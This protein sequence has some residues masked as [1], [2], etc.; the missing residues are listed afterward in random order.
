MGAE[1]T[2]KEGQLYSLHAE[3]C[4]SCSI[5]GDGTGQPCKR[6][7]VE[8]AGVLPC[9]LFCLSPKHGYSYGIMF[10]PK[11]VVPT[12]LDASVNPKLG[13]GWISQDT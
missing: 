13:S 2:D 4:L 9:Q 10:V 3:I 12:S 5:F 7:Q 11:S 8:E 6:S 1:P